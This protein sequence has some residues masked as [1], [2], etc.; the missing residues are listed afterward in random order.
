ME[1]KSHTGND[2]Y[3]C[4][5]ISASM[6]EIKDIKKLSIKENSE[7]LDYLY[8][9]INETALPQFPVRKKNIPVRFF[10]DRSGKFEEVRKQCKSKNF[11][12]SHL[13]KQY[14]PD[15]IKKNKKG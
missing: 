14:L 7:F 9:Q 1:R 3:I 13:Y 4:T 8:K 6:E 12:F 10:K 5:S 15:F 2:L 11:S